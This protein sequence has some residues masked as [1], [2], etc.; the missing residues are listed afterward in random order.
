MPG[1]G[2][3]IPLVYPVGDLTLELNGDEP[4]SAVDYEFT[5]PT[6][7]PEPI[8]HYRVQF[9]A[10]DG[11]EDAPDDDDTS[12]TIDELPAETEVM[13]RVAVVDVNGNEGEWVEAG[14]IETDPLS[15]TPGSLQDAWVPDLE[16]CFTDTG[17]TT[18]AAVGDLV[19]AWRSTT[20]NTMLVAPTSGDRGTLRQSGG[21]YYIEGPSRY[22]VAA[23]SDFRAAILAA[24]DRSWVGAFQRTAGTGE[25]CLFDVANLCAITFASAATKY[26]SVN[27]ASVGAVDSS[28]APTVVSFMQDAAK[29]WFRRN[30]VLT[31][32]FDGLN[33]TP[34][35]DEGFA[36]GALGA[37][38]G[39]LAMQMNCYGLAS[40]TKTL[41][42][43]ER[44][45]NERYF[46]HRCGATLSLPSTS[47][48]IFPSF[49]NS[50]G[51]WL[52]QGDGA[53][54]TN[55]PMLYTPAASGQYRDASFIYFDGFVWVLHTN[56][57]PDGAFVNCTEFAIGKSPDM[58][59]FSPA[60]RVDMSSVATGG[61]SRTWVGTWVFNESPQSSPYLS[62]GFPC[63]VVGVSNN[64]V[65]GPF[66]WY[67][68]TFS[69]F[70]NAAIT[71]DAITEIYDP[72]D[73]SNGP[74]II[75]NTNGT[76]TAWYDKGGFAPD[77][78]AAVATAPAITGPWTV[79]ESGD[80]MGAD[81]DQEG[82]HPLTLS[83]GTLRV[84]QVLL[85]FPVSGSSI[86]YQD[87][88]DGGVTWTTPQT[89][90]TAADD[91]TNTCP[92]YRFAEIAQS[93]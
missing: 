60:A 63:C 27:E 30:G 28:T 45:Q 20:G 8:D 88:T 50:G 91:T 16:Y 32:I 19:Y 21:K 57:L 13:V 72:G 2:G 78:Y 41:T 82:I 14:P 55:V 93:P 90:V 68:V 79:Q 67:L 80:W 73:Y 86:H 77:N 76:F 81:P 49:L 65:S 84:Y 74:H 17:G 92:F 4:S 40:Y 15:L 7:L 87:S 46:A 66:K 54:F 31:G 52:G 25:G 89:Q 58:A 62:G 9:D 6:T 22:R 36:I 42:P 3:L 35:A 51:V 33:N 70:S 64:G 24:T 10:G 61:D 18:P 71:V 85:P 48:I 75:A 59:F 47:D 83:N 5:A 29:V 69:A 26:Y 44:V 53:S 1:L 23:G 39:G 43:A 34:G 56:G 12:G 11:W 38:A 37:P